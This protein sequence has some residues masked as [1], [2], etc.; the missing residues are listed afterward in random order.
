MRTRILRALPAA[1]ATLGALCILVP[2]P[3][4]G[5]WKFHYAALELS[6]LLGMLGLVGA[7]LSRRAW[8]LIGL[9]SA[10]VA[11]W[12]AA[13]GLAL[14]HER[15]EAFSLLAWLGYDPE[16][17]IEVQTDL[18]L[19]PTRP[20]L[21]LDRYQGLGEGPRPW[22]LVIHGGSWLHGDKGEVSH[23]SRWLAAHGYTVFDVHYRLSDEAPFPAG[24]ADAKCLLGRVVGAAQELGVDPARG[25]LLGRSA[26]GHMV[27]LI[28]DSANDG[29]IPAACDVAEVR[30][31]KVIALYPAADLAWGWDNVPSPDII[32]VHHVQGL[33]LGGSPREHAETYAL[34]TPMNHL[35]PA[36]PPALVIH[37]LSDRLVSPH[38]SVAYAGAAHGQHV[39]V[40]LVTIPGAEHG[41]DVRHGGIAEQITRAEILRFLSGDQGEGPGEPVAR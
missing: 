8:G 6:L 34:A 39:P 3:T 22:V 27:L 25:A 13:Q 35:D 10:M 14:A 36:D 41:Y 32:Q 37:G 18:S 5:L 16:P 7:A 12:P 24:V 38:H 9:A 30:P 33:Y 4:F 21:L 11:L 2:M 15:G 17:A 1:I 40:T 28:A 29:T 19:E 26:G 23:V 20:D 31:S